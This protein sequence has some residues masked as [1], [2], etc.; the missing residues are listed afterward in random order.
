[1][2]DSSAASSP[3]GTTVLA[4]R[5]GP[6]VVLA[7]DGQVTLG[8]TVIKHGAQKLRRLHDGRVIAGFAGATADAFTLFALFEAKL[9]DFSANLP[10][11]AV[12]MARAW[13]GDRM[14]RRLE[15]MLLVASADK[16]LVVSGAGDVIDPDDEA[17]AIGSGGNFALAAARALLT[18][19]EMTAAAVAAAAMALAA[20]MCIYTNARVN[21]LGLGGPAGGDQAGMQQ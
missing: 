20:D 4:V 13:R 19:T 18:H 7:A 17:M 8:N 15:A 6:Q 3:H 16:T 1:M 9:K 14:L 2:H 12:E 10:R 11:A 21:T 5:R